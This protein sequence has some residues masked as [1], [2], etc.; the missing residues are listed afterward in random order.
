MAHY[1]RKLESSTQ[2]LIHLK[3]YFSFSLF[4]KDKCRNNPWCNLLIS[5]FCLIIY[6]IFQ[7]QLIIHV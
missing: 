6:I 5:T 7:N 2:D 3:D 4:S 1:V